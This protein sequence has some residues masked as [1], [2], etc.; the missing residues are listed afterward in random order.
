MATVQN[1]FLSHVLLTAV[2]GLVRVLRVVDFGLVFVVV[3][4]VFQMDDHVEGVGQDQQQD[5]GG[6]EAH[7]DGRSQEG[8]AVAR[9]GKFTRGDVERLNLTRERRHFI[10]V[11][12]MQLRM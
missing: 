9:R 3:L 10:K 4:D 2:F 11:E 1:I 8:G 7:Q 12:K 6:D 5:E